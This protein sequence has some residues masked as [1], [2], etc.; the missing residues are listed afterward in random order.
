MWAGSR[1]ARPHGPP[2]WLLEILRAAGWW[3]GVPAWRQGH[4]LEGARSQTPG[5]LGHRGLHNCSRGVDCCFDNHT[6][7]PCGHAPFG[8]P[9]RALLASGIALQP[10]GGGAAAG[11]GTSWQYELTSSYVDF[12]HANDAAPIPTS[13]FSLVVDYETETYSRWQFGRRS[14]PMSAEL[15]V[16]EPDVDCAHVQAWVAPEW[17]FNLRLLPV[18]KDVPMQAEAT[19]ESLEV[20]VHPTC[21]TRSGSPMEDR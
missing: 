19:L 10:I 13:N 20:L 6:L 9:C 21:P 14:W 11:D 15:G 5:L 17:E 2:L 8:K 18:D 1:G 12:D 16:Y 7:E 3:R 4:L